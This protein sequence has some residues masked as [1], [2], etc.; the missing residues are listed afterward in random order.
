MD[1]LEPLK[2]VD[3]IDLL[4]AKRQ[5]RRLDWIL[6]QLPDKERIIIS[7]MNLV[8]GR[9]RKVNTIEIGQLI[10]LGCLSYNYGNGML[11]VNKVFRDYIIQ[12]FENINNIE[13]EKEKKKQNDNP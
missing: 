4:R 2:I 10:D 12:L 11:S 13:K 7:K 8:L 6:T 1:N 5:F 3:G 9:G